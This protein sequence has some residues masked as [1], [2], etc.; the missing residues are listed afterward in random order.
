[1][2]YLGIDYG[3]KRVGLAL[4]DEAGTMGFPHAVVANTPR[5]S[6]E[7][8][9]RI[10]EKGV[11]MVVIG[12]SRDLQGGENPIAEKARALGDELSARAGVPIAYESEIYTSAEAR[13]AAGAQEKP[14]APKA[15]GSVDASAAALILTSYLSRRDKV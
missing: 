13:R 11:G 9:A 2:R 7:L 14:R 10:A 3:S 6:D 15:R 12:E 4:S 1:M 5:L 8:C